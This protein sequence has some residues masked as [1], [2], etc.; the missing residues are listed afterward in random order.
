MSGKSEDLLLVRDA[1]QHCLEIVKTDFLGDQRHT[2]GPQAGFVLL[3]ICMS[4]MLRALDREGMR[5]GFTDHVPEGFDISDQI[6]KMRN[7]VCHFGSSHRDLRRGGKV[8]FCILGHN[9]GGTGIDLGDYE[10][11]NPFEDDWAIYYGE[12]C[13]FLKRHIYRVMDE[14]GA[15]LEKEFPAR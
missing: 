7:A 14:V 10:M 12:L 9:P 5:V 4:D 13:L 15:V 3:M 8:V 11:S 2:W 6:Y 1:F